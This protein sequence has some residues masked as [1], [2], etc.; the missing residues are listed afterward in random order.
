MNCDAAVVGLL[1]LLGLLGRRLTSAMIRSTSRHGSRMRATLTRH[2]AD[3]RLR[4][5]GRHLASGASERQNG[6]PLRTA[7]VFALQQS[8]R[9]TRFSSS[10]SPR[11]GRR[12]LLRA[13]RLKS[14]L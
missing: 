10:I 5:D 8:H 14:T 3:M 6:D 11:G 7:S 1:I 4:A 2:D 13:V 12:F 9:T